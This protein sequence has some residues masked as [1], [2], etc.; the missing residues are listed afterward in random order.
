M[1]RRY[2]L[3][4]LERMGF[5]Y[6]EA[7]LGLWLA[8]GLGVQQLTDLSSYDKALVS[9]LPALLAGVKGLAARGVG[10]SETAAVLA[11]ADDTPAALPAH[12]RP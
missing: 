4:L 6:L 9:V 11:V 12:L 7:Y 8:S 5:T 1:T 3:D 10:S 2:L